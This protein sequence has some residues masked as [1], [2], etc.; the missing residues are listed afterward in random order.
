MSNED[1]DKEG[2]EES[3]VAVAESTPETKKPRMYR[4]VILNDDYTPMD[5]VVQV[6]KRFFHKTTEQATK[7]MLQ[8][9]YEGQGTAG[10]Y[11]AEIAET[12]V[13][14][15]NDFSRAN[16]HPLMCTMEAE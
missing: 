5:F 14:M 10:I 4:V 7:V 11:T 6:L 2:Q 1:I 8:I 3:G 9:H 13:V 16:D 12:K 15:V